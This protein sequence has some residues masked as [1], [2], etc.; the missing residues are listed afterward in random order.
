L[1][2]GVNGGSINLGGGG[3]GVNS[4]VN[5]G[6]FGFLERWVADEGAGDTHA[7]EERFLFREGRGRERGLKV[8]RSAWVTVLQFSLISR[9]GLIAHSIAET[10]ARLG[11]LF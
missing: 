2:A 8:R 5:G 4:G 9:N 11:S 10:S 7:G 3:R 6:Y 1:N